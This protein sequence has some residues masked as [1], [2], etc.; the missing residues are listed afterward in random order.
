MHLI[1]SLLHTEDRIS[2]LSFCKIINWL[3]IAHVQL[4]IDLPNSHMIK[5]KVK[6]IYIYISQIQE[7][8]MKIHWS[9]IVGTKTFMGKRVCIE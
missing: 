9:R 2:T 6:K 1:I 8:I 3:N 4:R 7:K 5:S